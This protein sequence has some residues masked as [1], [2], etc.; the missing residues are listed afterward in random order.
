M[1]ID[2]GSSCQPIN[3]FN[4]FNGITKIEYIYSLSLSLCM[5]AFFSLEFSKCI[6]SFDFNYDNVRAY[7]R[8][9][10][11]SIEYSVVTIIFVI[12]VWLFHCRR[13]RFSLMSVDDGMECV[14]VCIFHLDSIVW[15]EN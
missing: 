11:A 15:Q 6:H 14:R 13:H 4:L 5:V 3:Y 7:E 8:V 2:N 10:D 1:I 9:N 12:L